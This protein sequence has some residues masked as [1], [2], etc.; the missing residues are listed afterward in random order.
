MSYWYCLNHHA[1][2]GQDGCDYKDRLG[3][4]DTE[5]EAAR[6]LEK[7]KERNEAWDNDPRWNDE[8]ED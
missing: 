4:Y 8:L 6:A 7:V 5:E 1:V 3:P 2:E